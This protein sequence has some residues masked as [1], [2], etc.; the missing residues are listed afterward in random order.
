MADVIY[1]LPSCRR[2]I[3]ERPRFYAAWAIASGFSALAAFLAVNS[4][5]ADWYRQT[6][7]PLPATIGTTTA[8]SEGG[9][10]VLTMTVRAEPSQA[11]V[12]VRFDLLARPDPAGSFNEF[13]PL[14]SNASGHLIGL[15]GTFN[16]INEV[17]ANIRGMWYLHT[18][19]MHIC[20]V[21]EWLPAK[22]YFRMA[23]VRT[24]YF[25]KPQPA[26]EAAP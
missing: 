1:K 10:H 6:E 8:P 4:T 24:V 7:P 12:R 25:G 18:R 5:V 16:I 9:R 13:I 2:L 22:V 21:A 14:D 15:P 3:K 23:P 19:F 17:P 11:C 20:T 26:G